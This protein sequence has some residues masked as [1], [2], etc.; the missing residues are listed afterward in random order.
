VE[1]D[2]A[3][4]TAFDPNAGA[5][6]TGTT[7]SFFEGFQSPVSDADLNLV[8]AGQSVALKWKLFCSPGV[9]EPKLELVYRHASDARTNLKRLPWYRSHV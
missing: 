8:K 7:F 5:I 3:G 6:S 9:W 4:V 1:P 2:R